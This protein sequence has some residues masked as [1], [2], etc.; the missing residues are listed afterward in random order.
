MQRRQNLPSFPVQTPL[1]NSRPRLYGLARPRLPTK[2]NAPKAAPSVTQ[3]FK[4][5]PWLSYT[6]TSTGTEGD[7]VTKTGRITCK[8]NTVENTASCDETL[9]EI[10]DGTTATATYTQEYVGSDYNL[11]NIPITGGAAKTENPGPLCVGDKDG[12]ASGLSVK[13][14]AIWALVGAMGAVG[15]LAL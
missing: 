4:G 2:S 8:Q 14:M 9:T 10:M 15:F 1:R 12:A 13:S 6:T 11:Y 7:E 5:S 3:E